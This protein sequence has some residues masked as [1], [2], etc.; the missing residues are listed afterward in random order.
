MDQLRLL[1]LSFGHASFAFALK[2]MGLR[3]GGWKRRYEIRWAKSVPYLLFIS[4]HHGMHLQFTPVYETR[5]KS[6]I[7]QDVSDFFCHP[8]TSGYLPVPALGP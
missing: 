6:M 5:R 1:I 7:S 4:G 2:G 8:G 3:P